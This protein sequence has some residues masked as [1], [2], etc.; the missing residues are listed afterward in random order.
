MAHSRLVKLVRDRVGEKLG[1]TEVSYEPILARDQAIKELRKKL[2][3]E[4]VEYIEDPSI[5][6]LAD[7]LEIVYSLASQDLNV[8]FDEV[9]EMTR[10]KA[11]DL[12]GFDA[13][14]G[15]YV[16]VKS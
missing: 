5:E 6:E 16:T 15:M 1:H 11:L 12:G 10:A 4:A 8:H 14:I 9:V 3:E 2:I 7:I 13:L